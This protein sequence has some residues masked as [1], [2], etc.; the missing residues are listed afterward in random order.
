MSF[1]ALSLSCSLCTHVVCPQ[2]A[3]GHDHVEKLAD[4]ASVTDNKKGFGGK[5]GVQKDR[6][7]QV[8]R[9][10]SP[11]AGSLITQSGIGVSCVGLSMR[12]VCVRSDVPFVALFVVSACQSAASYSY[13][14]TTDKHS[15]QKDY[16]SGFGGKFGVQKDR[17]DKV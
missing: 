17:T 13:V 3:V 11:L 5:F 6:V 14:G 4:H 10:T 7:D 9:F 16:T 1:A 15:S 12:F 8:R 2:A